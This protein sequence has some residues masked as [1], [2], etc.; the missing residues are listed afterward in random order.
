MPDTFSYALANT[1]NQSGFV[2][3]NLS[4][5]NLTFGQ[6][7]NVTESQTLGVP[8]ALLLL[9]DSAAA[10][11]L[12]TSAPARDIARANLSWQMSLGYQQQLIGS[13]TL[14]PRLTLQGSM[15]RTDTSSVTQDFVSAP[16]RVALG[17]QLKTDIYG[18]FPG[19][20]SFETIRHKFSPSFDYQWSPES[21]PTL[22][23]RSV[24][25]AQ[26]LQPKNTIAVTLNQ[27]FEAKREMDE[28]AQAAADSA[29]AQANAGALGEPRRI[30]QAEIVSLLALRTS[31]VQYDFV[32]A[33]SAGSFL[34]GFQTTRLSN[35]ISSDILRGL[36]ISTD[37]D[38][39]DDT[40]DES[41][42]IVDRRFAP[43]LAQVNLGFSL[44]SSS[45]VF[46]WL[47]S[48]WGGESAGEPAPEEPGADEVLDPFDVADPTDEASVIPTGEQAGQAPV[49]SR[50]GPR[51]SW[52]ANLSY[53]LQ[54]PRDPALESRQMLTG[55]LR[56]QP[57]EKWAL[58]WRT[59]YDIERGAFNDHAIRLTR[60]LHRWQANFDFLQTAT[61]NWSFRF[62]V[63]L[64][65]NRDLKFDYDQ[66]NLDLGLPAEE[67]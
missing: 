42:T 27:T 58:S 6:S 8:E 40:K 19:F 15:L 63:S 13:T 3:S 44:G 49:R 56:L 18:F 16:T 54:R 50:T 43:H 45:T 64:M 59:A 35:Q 17:A 36:S 39:F 1:V 52:T 23:Q 51:G 4:I 60:D 32:Q 31:V 47:S 37:H 14:T 11:D 46:R 26:V 22:L 30:P 65:D 62:E 38:L 41:G 12:L 9:G 2:R 48:L 67:R 66:Q 33:D 29:A 25:G 21:T 53:S 5:G 34:Q 7:V 28:E 61:G 10:P 24:F 55:S 57:T 20:G